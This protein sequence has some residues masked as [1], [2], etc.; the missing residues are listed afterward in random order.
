[1]FSPAESSTW[2]DTVEVAGTEVSNRTNVSVEGFRV[3]TT[4]GASWRALV[5]PP[6]GLSFIAVRIER[7]GEIN[8]YIRHAAASTD[9]SA[10][11]YTVEHIAHGLKWGPLPG[12]AI[13]ATM[14]TIEKSL[15][16]CIKTRS[17]AQ[18]LHFDVDPNGTVAHLYATIDDP[19]SNACVV[20]V[21]RHTR[22][23]KA[24]DGTSVSYS[25][26]PPCDADKLLEAGSQAVARG[27]YADGLKSYEAALDC[28]YDDHAVQLSL[29]AA[30]RAGNVAAARRH[31]KTLSANAQDRLIQMC[32]HNHIT[33]EQLD[34]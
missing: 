24:S 31:W 8:Y 2:G 7:D 15:L 34:E 17:D 5:K 23:A 18:T 4:P 1:V 6:A 3:S 9:K 26:A 10:R 22:F 28:R 33:R 13:D 30:C 25:L 20:S 21:V 29:M 11:H 12:E 27:V 16:G 32:L 19:V 14:K